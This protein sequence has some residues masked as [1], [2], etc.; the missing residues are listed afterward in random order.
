MLGAV[1]LAS[2]LFLHFLV[3]GSEKDRTSQFIKTCKD[4]FSYKETKCIE[5]MNKY[6]D[7]MKN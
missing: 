7:F 2:A 4:V 5:Y 3:Q 6:A 1:L